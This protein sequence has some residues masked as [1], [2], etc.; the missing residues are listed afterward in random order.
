MIID[1]VDFNQ[2]VVLRNSSESRENE[3]I[4][5]GKEREGGRARGSV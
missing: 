4:K 3:N 5:L 2:M 1:P